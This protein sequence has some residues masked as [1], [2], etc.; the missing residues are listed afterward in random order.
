[1]IRGA[2]VGV[3]SAA[4]AA[5]VG[6]A[7]AARSRRR[8]V[9]PDTRWH[10]LTVHKP[11]DELRAAPLPEPLTRLGDAV[12]VELRPAAGDKGTEIAVRLREGDPSGLSAAFDRIADRDPRHAVRRALREAKCLIETGEVL[13]PDARPSNRRTIL[14]RP[15]EYATGHGREEGLL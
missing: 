6:G 10:V 5:A 12:Q 13:E 11:L 14:N 15:L 7:L 9:E 2:L 3:A 1:M 8:R 4:G